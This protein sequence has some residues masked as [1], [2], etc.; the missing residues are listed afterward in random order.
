MSEVTATLDITREVCPMTYVRTKLRLEAL[1][2]GAL[3]EVLLRGTE[4][5][6]NVPRSAREEGHEVVS[7]ESR[8][9]GTHRLVLRKQGR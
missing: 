7:L 3:L 4:P 5:L 8:D 6:K 9:D 1:E 2:S